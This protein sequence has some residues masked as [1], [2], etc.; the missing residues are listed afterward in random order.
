MRALCLMMTVSFFL[1]AGCRHDAPG[2]TPPDAART[3]DQTGPTT[4]GSTDVCDW[5]FTCSDYSGTTPQ[6]A[7]HCTR[8]AGTSYTCT[9]KIGVVQT[10]TITLPAACSAATDMCALANSGCGWQPLVSCIGGL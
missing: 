2:M 4:A 8:G 5:G 9:C 1:A 10:N 7:L 6:Y 3:C